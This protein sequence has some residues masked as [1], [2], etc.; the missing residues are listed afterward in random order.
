MQLTAV[1]NPIRYCAALVGRLNRGVFTPELGL[2]VADKRRAETRC[3]VRLREPL[4]AARAATHVQGGRLPE[5]IRASLERMRARSNSRLP[6]DE[7]MNTGPSASSVLG[8]TD[9]DATH[10]QAR[11][12]NKVP[13][14]R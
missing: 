2:Q 8:A 10:A 14:D 11:P 13:G 12:N 3:E 9:G 7:S 5:N 1:N 6:I 4:V